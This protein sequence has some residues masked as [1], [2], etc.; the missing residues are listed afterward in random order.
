[1]PR[2]TLSRH[3]TSQGEVVYLREPDGGT[4]VVL[5]GRDLAVAPPATVPSPP[6][7]GLRAR[8]GQRMLAAGLHLL[9]DGEGEA[10]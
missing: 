10:A 8:L 4:R 1:M 3:Q 9:D 5:G 2:T 7:T 6:P